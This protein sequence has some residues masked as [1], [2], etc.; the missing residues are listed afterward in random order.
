M[1]FAGIGIGVAGTL[2]LA[3]S[4]GREMRS[5]IR[6][7]ANRSGDYLRRKAGTWKSSLDDAVEGG[8]RLVHEGVVKGASSISSL[9]GKLKDKIDDVSDRANDAADN[10]IDEAKGLVNAAG[11]SIEKVGKHLQ[12][13]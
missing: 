12:D 6:A 5:R 9:K 4:S 11:E 2:L 7:G 8:E 3:S 10:A 13:A 1:F